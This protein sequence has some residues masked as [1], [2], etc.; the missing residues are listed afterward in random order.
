MNSNVKACYWISPRQKIVRLKADLN[1]NLKEEK[2][3][4]QS[5]LECQKKLIACRAKTAHIKE[6]IGEQTCEKHKRSRLKREQESEESSSDQENTFK[7][8][9]R[10]RRQRRKRAW[11]ESSYNQEDP[12]DPEVELPESDFHTS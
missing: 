10:A 2:A 4:E 7:Q 8:H 3:I 5:F 1:K 12:E 11:E 6:R 9:E